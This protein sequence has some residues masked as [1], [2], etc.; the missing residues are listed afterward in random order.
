VVFFQLIE[1][2]AVYLLGLWIALQL[3]DALTA[4]GRET[5]V[6][7]VAIFAH[8]AGFAVGVAVALADRRRRPRPADAF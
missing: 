7:G 4:L 3:I 2:P 5:T 6:D 1:V 8:V